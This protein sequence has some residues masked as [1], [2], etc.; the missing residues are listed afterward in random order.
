ME[1]R[2]ETDYECQADF[3]DNDQKNIDE[4]LKPRNESDFQNFENIKNL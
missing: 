1:V 4:D 3:V 2:D